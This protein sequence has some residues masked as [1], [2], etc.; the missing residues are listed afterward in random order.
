MSGETPLVLS[1][2]AAFLI[3]GGQ[4]DARI[5]LLDCA[6]SEGRI[7]RRITRTVTDD[8]VARVFS[9]VAMN[10]IAI[11]CFE[12][13]KEVVEEL[14]DFDDSIIREPRQRERDG[15]AIGLHDIPPCRATATRRWVGDSGCAK[16]SR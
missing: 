1:E 14:M 9:M 13:M 8:L 6:D 10:L 5:G 3:V 7:V 11:V 15:V 16:T 12:D 4:K 2:P